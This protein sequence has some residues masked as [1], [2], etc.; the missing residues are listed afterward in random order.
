MGALPLDL[1]KK[2]ECGGFYEVDRGVDMGFSG[3]G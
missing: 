2:I 3:R 1:V